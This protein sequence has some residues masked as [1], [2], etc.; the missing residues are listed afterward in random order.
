MDREAFFGTHEWRRS[1]DG[2]I[3]LSVAIHIV[4]L[5]F[6][7]QVSVG[8]FLRN[9]ARK[10]DPG[11]DITEWTFGG[12]VASFRSVNMVTLIRGTTALSVNAAASEM[13]TSPRFYR[14]RRRRLQALTR[15]A[16]RPKSYALLSF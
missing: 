1:R 4:G 16:E 10:V 5:N 7:K 9:A 2:N 13:T 8:D 14:T 3:R 6:S 12:S 11:S 15:R